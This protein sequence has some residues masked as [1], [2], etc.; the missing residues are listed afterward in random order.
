MYSAFHDTL[1]QSSFTENLHLY[2]KFSSLQHKSICNTKQEPLNELPWPE[3][4]I[5]KPL[6]TAYSKTPSASIQ[7]KP[8]VL[9]SQIMI[10]FFYWHLYVSGL[11]LSPSFLMKSAV[12]SAL[13]R[14]WTNGLNAFTFLD[15]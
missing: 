3:C 14:V 8:L 1:L 6:T 5:T 11:L 4:S 15:P 2:I 7:Y 12:F 13:E 9:L 10:L